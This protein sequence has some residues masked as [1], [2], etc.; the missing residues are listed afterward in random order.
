MPIDEFIKYLNT[1]TL[2]R[3]DVDDKVASS[4]GKSSTQFCFDIQHE[5]DE[6]TI[7]LMQ[8]ATDKCSSLKFKIYKVEINRKYR[9]HNPSSI[10]YMYSS[11]STKTRS[12]FKRM[13]L[14]YGRYVLIATCSNSDSEI[15]LRI[16]SHKPSNLKFVHSYND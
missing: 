10:D 6:I 3:I 14:S 11:E 12:I 5:N 1:I 8:K 15:Y 16:S 13:K 9:I 4:I 2:C 7:E